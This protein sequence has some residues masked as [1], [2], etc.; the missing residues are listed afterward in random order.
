MLTKAPK[1]T[2]IPGTPAR[3]AREAYT[4]CQAP[5]S[6]PSGSVG[7]WQ[8]VCSVISISGASGISVPQGAFVEFINDENGNLVAFRIC[9]SEWVPNGS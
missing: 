8:M 4:L 3:E 2:I 9:R 5:P 1:I 6:P 7:S